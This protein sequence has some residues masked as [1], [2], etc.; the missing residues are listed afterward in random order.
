MSSGWWVSSRTRTRRGIIEALEPLLIEVVITRSTSPRA[1]DPDDLGAVAADVF[2]MTASRWSTLLPDALERAIALAEESGAELGAAGVLVTG[3]VVIVGEARAPAPRSRPGGL[4]GEAGGMRA[5]ASTVLVFE[6]IV[7][8][9][10]IPVALSLTDAST[11]L[12]CWI[13]GGL[14]VLAS[15]PAGLLRRPWGIRPGVG[16]AGGAS[17]PVA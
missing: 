5:L 1:L 16:P 2:G 7:V 14:A 15:S 13:F 17:S 6:A 8:F 10:A 12:V 4:I 3:S 9:L 11:A